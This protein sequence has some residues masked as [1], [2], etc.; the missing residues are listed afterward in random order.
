MKRAGVIP[1]LFS[2]SRFLDSYGAGAVYAHVPSMNV[3]PEWRTSHTS[4][5]PKGL[6]PVPKRTETP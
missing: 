5:K 1:A 4:L 2:H 3:S 6:A